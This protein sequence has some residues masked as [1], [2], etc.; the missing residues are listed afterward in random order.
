MVL[1]INP[2]TEDVEKPD[3][4]QAEKCVEYFV[5]DLGIKD[6]VYTRDITQDGD[7]WFGFIF[8]KNSFSMKVSFPGI[9]ADVTRE[10]VPFKSRRIYVDGS[11]WLWGYGLGIFTDKYK[12]YL[13]AKEK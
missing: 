2:G 8:T 7:G 5:K 3:I 6:L 12:D 1:I 10:S 13:L 4:K 11:S 9:N